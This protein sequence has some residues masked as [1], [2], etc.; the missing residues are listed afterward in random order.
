[1]TGP[2]SIKIRQRYGCED[3]PVPRYM[4]LHAA[5]MDV[6]AACAGDVVIT[7]GE[8]KRVPCG[9]TM[10]VPVGYE[11]QIRPR[12]GLA[13][14]HGIVVPNSPGT[15]DADYRGE[16]CV[17]LGNIG[18]EPFVVTRGMRIAQMVIAPVTQV[19]VERVDGLPETTRGA[20]GFG[21]T[22]V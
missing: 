7:P 14:K 11:A 15:I 16:V 19:G 21:H 22:G 1:M 4:S 18:A 9:F 10:A 12:S 8:I 17:L 6:C 13:L 5:G 3:V 2:I 20:G